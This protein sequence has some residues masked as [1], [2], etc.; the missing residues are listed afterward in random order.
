MDGDCSRHRRID[1]RTKSSFDAL[2]PLI[3]TQEI[4]GDV[5]LGRTLFHLVSGSAERTYMP[6]Y[7]CTYIQYACAL[8]TVLAQ[9]FKAGRLA[10]DAPYLSRLTG[11]NEGHT[12]NIFYCT[13][14]IC[15]IF[16]S[17]AAVN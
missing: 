11:S 13:L 10:T 1:G 6:L 7:V 2:F 14:H 9:K 12:A 8:V 3:Q 16:E 17:V 4:E 5:R 15:R